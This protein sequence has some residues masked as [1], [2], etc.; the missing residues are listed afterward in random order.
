MTAHIRTANQGSLS[1]LSTSERD[2]NYHAVI[3]CDGNWR[4]IICKDRIQWIIQRG[5]KTGTERR[6]RG[7]SYITCKMALM[8]L[9][10][11]KTGACDEYFTQLPD[12]FAEVSE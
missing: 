6:W 12:K 2:D 10:A 9:W 8:R 11:D 7:D 4:I 3:H 5:K 1:G